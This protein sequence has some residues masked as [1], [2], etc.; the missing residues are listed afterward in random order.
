MWPVF[1]CAQN[2]MLGHTI[3]YGTEDVLNTKKLFNAIKER[4]LGA[5]PN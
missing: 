5:S 4:N 1:I 3:K 2:P